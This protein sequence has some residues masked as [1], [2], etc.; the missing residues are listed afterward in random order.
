[1]YFVFKT[2]KEVLQILSYDDNLA[3]KATYCQPG[4]AL[5]VKPCFPRFASVTFRFQSFVNM[6]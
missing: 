3:E 5:M 1:M 4:K 6:I 2:A